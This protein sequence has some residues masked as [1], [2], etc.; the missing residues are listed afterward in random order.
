MSSKS[1]SRNVGSPRG[2][3]RGR[4]VS[5]RKA[6]ESPFPSASPASAVPRRIESIASVV[7]RSLSLG[8]GAPIKWHGTPSSELLTGSPASVI[9]RRM[10]LIA[11]VSRSSGLEADGDDLK[12]TAVQD[13]YRRFIQEKLDI[14]WEKYPRNPKETEE[15]LRHRINT[16]ENVLIMFRKLRE[17]VISSKRVGQFTNEVYETSLYVAVLF[18]SPRHISAI[19]PALLTH[20][21]L[22]STEPH[23]HCDKAVLIC[24]LQ[25]LVAGYPSQR[26]FHSYLASVPRAFFPDNSAMSIW[27]TSLAGC[28]RTQNYAKIDQLTRLSSLPVIESESGPQL[29][30]KALYHLVHTFRNKTREMAWVV[31]R[32]AYRELS[33]Q[34]DPQID[35]R[36]WLQ[37]SLGLHNSF[38]AGS[39]ID[40]DRWLE[41]ESEHGHVVKKDG[42]EGRW[43][44][45]KP[46]Q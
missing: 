26:E 14:L 4:P 16:Q 17:G 35:T 15:E 2:S 12:N 9:P 13:E 34:V 33:C 11:S 5:R 3:P 32:T 8:N 10:E 42:V 40:L 18:D 44:I 46:R 6:P 43:I 29:A 45:R 30:R 41:Q 39:N 7:S 20:F 25:H 37:R 23:P 19:V 31:I 21:R 1:S 22:A 28:V 27:I 24:L 38:P 36:K